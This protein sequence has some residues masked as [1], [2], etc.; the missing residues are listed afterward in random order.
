MEKKLLPDQ[1]L[2]HAFTQRHNLTD[3]QVEQFKHYY[4]L[5]IQENDKYNLTTITDL[6]SV[7]TYHFDDS[8][9]LLS[10]IDCRKISTFADIGTGAGFPAIPLKI[11]YPHL[12]AIL[13]EVQ[14]K[15]IT[16]LQLVMSR[17]R[18]DSIT[19][20]ASDWRTFLRKTT[21]PI[22]LFCA[23]ASL[24]PEELIRVFKPSSFYRNTCLVYWAS[25]T[26]Q[27]QKKEL[28]FIS[29]QVEYVLGNKKRKLVVFRL[30]E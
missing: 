17:L 26:W 28:P 27:P 1:E 2:W 15:R 18:L 20:V 19:V 22:E 9:A 6:A 25:M 10:I 12:H 14:H 7:I 16:F 3:Y 24:H 11:V 5:L 23:R 21:F 4:L 13:I 8:L 29:C 30:S